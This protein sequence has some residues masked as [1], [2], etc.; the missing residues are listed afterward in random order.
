MQSEREPS[1]RRRGFLTRCGHAQVKQITADITPILN[2]FSQ[3]ILQNPNAARV[4]S[5]LTSAPEVSAF[6]TQV[7]S[8]AAMLSPDIQGFLVKQL[9]SD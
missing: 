6:V 1:W 4:L 2:T 7:Q 9:R 8:L 3:G 5:S